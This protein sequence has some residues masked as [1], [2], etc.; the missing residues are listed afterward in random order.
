MLLVTILVEEALALA[1]QEQA[2]ALVA[3]V[4][5]HMIIQD[6]VAELEDQALARRAILVMVRQVLLL[7]VV[8]LLPLE[9]AA[10]QVEAHLMVGRAALPV[11]AE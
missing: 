4:A 3:Q 11:A 7:F 1:L 10:D 5:P 6:M 2:A 8:T 9:A